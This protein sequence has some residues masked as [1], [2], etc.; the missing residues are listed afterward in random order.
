MSPERHE[1]RIEGHLGSSWSHRF[2]GMSIRRQADGTTVLSGPLVDQ[3]ALHGV[4]MAIRDLGL[5]LVAVQR[6]PEDV[7]GWDGDTSR[8]A[9]GGQD[10]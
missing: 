9:G 10:V 5:I 4:L 6:L 1:I 2:A 8:K 7:Q 3:A